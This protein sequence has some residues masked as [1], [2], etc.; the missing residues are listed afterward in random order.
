MHGKDRSKKVRSKDIFLAANHRRL[1]KKLCKGLK[2]SCKAMRTSSLTLRRRGRI[3]RTKTRVRKTLQKKERRA[4]DAGRVQQ[5]S[6]NTSC[7]G[8]AAAGISSVSDEWKK[9]WRKKR[10]QKQED[11]PRQPLQ[12]EQIGCHSQ[13]HLSNCKESTRMNTC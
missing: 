8:G 5:G 9:R 10:S 13:S 12:K 2:K 1:A 11:S 7:C 3:F 6:T 4:I